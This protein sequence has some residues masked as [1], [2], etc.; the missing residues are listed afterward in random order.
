LNEFESTVTGA[1]KTDPRYSYSVY[2]TGDKFDNNTAT[3]VDADQNGASSTVHGVKLK[4]GWR[5]FQLIYKEDRSTAAFH[6]G[7][8]NQ[9][10]VRFAEVLLMLAEC[11][12]E[13]G[14]TGAAVGYLNQV[15]ARPDVAMPPYPTAQFPVATKADMVKAIMH[16]KNG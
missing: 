5:K 12:N 9:R 6:P 4:V 2:Q 3:L 13:L 16:E 10:I 15:R 14:N 7:S 1:A 8:N 11:E